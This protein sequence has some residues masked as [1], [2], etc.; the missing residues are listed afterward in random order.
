LTA[1]AVSANVKRFF[2]F[3]REY[4]YFLEFISV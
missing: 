4:Q 3:T 2:G 1:R